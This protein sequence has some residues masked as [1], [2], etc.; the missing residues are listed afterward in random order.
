MNGIVELS[1]GSPVQ[2]NS[3]GCS[4]TKV[5]LSLN[6][7]EVLIAVEDMLRAKTAYDSVRYMVAP[8][9]KDAAFR[10]AKVAGA[11]AVYQSAKSKAMNLWRSFPVYLPP[12]EWANWQA[13]LEFDA[14]KPC[15]FSGVAN[16]Y[17]TNYTFMRTLTRI[18]TLEFI[19]VTNFVRGEIWPVLPRVGQYNHDTES[20]Y[21]KIVKL[22]N[23]GDHEF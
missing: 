2:K 21:I 4:P 15:D 1:Y 12:D 5:P 17:Y 3:P 6:T 10:A 11:T 16:P 9:S 22:T 14:K 13:S 18:P 23:A 19:T 7:K 20:E 8:N